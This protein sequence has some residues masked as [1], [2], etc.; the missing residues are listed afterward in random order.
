MMIKKTLISV[1][2]FLALL[3]IIFFS[4]L[5][6]FDTGILFSYQYLKSKTIEDYRNNQTSLFQ[7][8]NKK[9]LIFDNNNFSPIKGLINN[10]K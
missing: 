7:N 3:F 9:N 5:I 6:L 1:I 8:I 10:K 2:I 4:Y